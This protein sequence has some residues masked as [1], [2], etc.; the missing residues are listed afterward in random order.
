VDL[1]RDATLS[2]INS[3]LIGLAEGE[4]SVTIVALRLDAELS[5]KK[6]IAKLR[7]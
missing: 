5:D 2:H 6:H 7:L 3:R 4:A 1:S